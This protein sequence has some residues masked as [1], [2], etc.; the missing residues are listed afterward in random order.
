MKTYY[1]DTK[2]Q[3]VWI[4][5]WYDRKIRFWTCHL[6]DAPGDEGNQISHSIYVPHRSTIVLNADKYNRF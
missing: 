1:A 6:V 3:G 5:Y 2:E 4:R